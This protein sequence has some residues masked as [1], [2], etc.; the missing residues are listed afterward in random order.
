MNAAITESPAQ[1]EQT[2]LID[3]MALF[4]CHRRLV[5]TG[6]MG[7][8]KTTAGRL[9]AAR[10][11]WEFL[12]LDNLIEVRA[13]MTVPAI[14]AAHGE[15]H[16]RRLESQ[17]LAAA[18]GRNHIVLALG[19]GA[20]EVLTNRLL[21]EQTPGTAAVFLDA[22][23]SVLF[24]RCMMQA[25]NPEPG[26]STGHM[27]GLSDSEPSTLLGQARPVF[28]NP[29]SA[30]ARFRTRHPIYRRLARHQVQTAELSTRAD[31]CGDIGAFEPGARAR[32]ARNLSESVESGA[33]VRRLEEHALTPAQ[34]TWEQPKP[35]GARSNILFTIGVLLALALAW[36]LRDV[37]LLIYVSALFAV[38]LTPAVNAIMIFELRGGRH[39]TRAVAIATLL[40]LTLLVLTLFLG[41][42]LP[43]VVHDLR[44]FTADLPARSDAIVTKLK[45]LPL[46]DKLGFDEIAGRVESALSATVSYLFASFP[47][48]ITRIFD[49]LTT[50]VLCI[51]F[52]LEG[53]RAYAWV[54]SLLPVC[55]RLR[56]AVTLEKAEIRMSKWLFGQG[57]LMLILGVASTIA[58]GLM[59]VRYFFLLGVL[60]GLM[61][62]VPIAGGVITILLV[63]A[64]AALDSW[65][66]MAGVFLFYLIYVNIEN[67][68]LTPRIMRSNL[69]LMGL[70]VLI[71]L[72]AGT[73]LAG[74]VGALVAVPTAALIAV[75]MDEYMVQKD[76]LT[77]IAPTETSPDA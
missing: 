15:A 42:G 32:Q 69:D 8:G 68:Y 74:V 37:L 76:D 53:D 44:Q 57:L 11:G 56:L 41:L 27:P 28:A 65:T 46:A 29:E 71:A 25:L 34:T 67:A 20:P 1:S 77:V 10:L 55:R 31:G 75:L 47:L 13:G 38:V 48:W 30:E 49:I 62:I 40:T 3:P 19:G 22:P 64:I 60:M 70:T 33:A 24:D 17:A 26:L 54:M 36:Q 6:F 35:P 58:F 43:P 51:Y 4:P 14:F 18:L 39:I 23:F 45:R 73:E 52:M 2:S 7:A 66:K 5:L 12:D 9:L 61:N 59:H 21:I 72:I 16:F 63:G 50:F